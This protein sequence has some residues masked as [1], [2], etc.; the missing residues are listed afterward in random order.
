VGEERVNKSS[1][2]NLGYFVNVV[3]VAQNVEQSRI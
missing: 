1:R 2:N 3:D